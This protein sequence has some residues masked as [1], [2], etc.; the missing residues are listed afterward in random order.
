MENAAHIN[1]LPDQQPF[2][3]L[4]LLYACFTGFF[5]FASG[6]IAGYVENYMVYGK[7]RGTA[8]QFYCF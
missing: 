3:S 5:L 8:P 4:A 1:Y 6:I 2:H 7:S